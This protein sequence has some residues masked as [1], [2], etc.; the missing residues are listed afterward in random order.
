MG[1]TRYE[2]RTAIAQFFGGTTQQVDPSVTGSYGP[3][4]E[5]PLQSSGLS[6]VYPRWA[7]RI[8]D[9]NFFLFSEPARAMG[10]CMVV[11]IPR[12]NEHR[13]SIPGVSPLVQP[14]YAG[15]KQDDMVVELHL[16]HLAQQNYAE[17]AEEDFEQMIDAIIDR[18][19]TDVTLGGACVQAGEDKFG[20]QT[21]MNPPVT[22]D[23]PERIEQ[24]AKITF[25]VQYFFVA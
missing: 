14:N 15:T 6:A 12:L 16:Y 25:R 7:K 21:I 1:G 10:T 4:I 22:Q 23:V 2:A 18:I 17:P 19:E 9:S 11:H 13:L 3:Y 20:I 24:Y 8:P 5:G